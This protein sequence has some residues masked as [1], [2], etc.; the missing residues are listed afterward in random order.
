MFPP[1]KILKGLGHAT[2]VEDPEKFNKV[3]AE[4]LEGMVG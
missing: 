4:F 2:Y 1:F 3:I